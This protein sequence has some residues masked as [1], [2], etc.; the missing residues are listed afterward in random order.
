M[1]I[2][3]EKLSKTY[4]YDSLN[5]VFINKF[6]LHQHH[7]QKNVRYFCIGDFFF[8]SMNET[9]FFS[10][11]CFHHIFHAMSWSKKNHRVEVLSEGKIEKKNLECFTK[12][13]KKLTSESM[14]HVATNLE[15]RIPYV[16]KSRQVVSHWFKISY[17]E[18]K[19][20]SVH[21]ITMNIALN[22]S[23]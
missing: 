20:F 3:M 7:A 1:L 22:K 19:F 17:S 23:D 10:D 11:N 5:D 8:K 12:Y 21:Q 16:I 4:I 15:Y 2:N 6:L 9:S 13:K 14:K 18:N